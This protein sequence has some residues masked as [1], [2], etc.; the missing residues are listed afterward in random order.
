MSL[1]RMAEQSDSAVLPGRYPRAAYDFLLEG[2]GYTVERVHGPLTPEQTVV[3]QYMAHEEI[4]LQEV[5][6]RR[7]EGVLDPAVCEAIDEAGGVEQLNR[8]VGG[9]ELCWA[10]RDRALMRWG[11]L[12]VPVLRA[13]RITETRHWGEMVFGLISCGRLQREPH[14]RIEDFADVFDFKE[15]LEDAHRIDLA[16]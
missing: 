7:E 13:W 5:I 4:D 11:L 1:K 6:E 2:L 16:D 3:A 14:D 8:H 12:A 10:L 9:E 15:A